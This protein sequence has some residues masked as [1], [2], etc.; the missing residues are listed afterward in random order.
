[1][2]AGLGDLEYQ[3][4]ECCTPVPGDAI[5]GVI[6]GN[7]EVLIHRQDC[8]QALRADIYGHLMR[9]DWQ[10]A[11]AK[12]FPVEI[13]VDAY[14]RPGLL[15]DITGIF[16]HAQTNVVSLSSET[17]HQSRRVSLKMTIEIA[18]INSLLTTLEKIEQLSNVV[19]ARRI[20]SD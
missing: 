20:A 11:K 17:N 6:N 13:E 2:I 16:M 3:I 8:L 4:A 15:Y 19:S 5:V 9:L 18:S 7:S 12:T 1:M 10:E 14:D